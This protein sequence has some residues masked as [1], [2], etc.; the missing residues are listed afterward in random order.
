MTEELFS[1]FTHI[2]FFAM[3]VVM[4][5]YQFRLVERNYERYVRSANFL[6]NCYLHLHNTLEEISHDRSSQAW[7]RAHETI[8][9]SKTWNLKV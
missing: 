4:S 9:I 1:I 7:M 5:R 6:H 3:G 8:Q 2:V